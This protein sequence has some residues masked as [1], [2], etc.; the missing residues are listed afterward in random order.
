MLLKVKTISS[1]MNISTN[2]MFDD[3]TKLW[4]LRLGHMGER[5]MYEHSKQGLFD[6]KKFRTLG[7]ANNVFK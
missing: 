5:S 4:Q 7:F 6:G 3:E 1:S 2:T